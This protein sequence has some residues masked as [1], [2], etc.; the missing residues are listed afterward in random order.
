MDSALD[1]GSKGCGFESRRGRRLLLALWP[2]FRRC[3]CRRLL[4]LPMP[5]A[6]FFSLYASCVSLPITFAIFLTF[7][8]FSALSVCITFS[9][10]SLTALYLLI[11][12]SLNIS[13]TICR[14]SYFSSFIRS[15]PPQYH[16]AFASGYICE[17]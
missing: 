9:L 14:F 4:F 12:E 6:G 5:L 13:T 11:L 16:C 17:K 3:L 15:M 2:F 8:I 7:T 1:F 10:Y